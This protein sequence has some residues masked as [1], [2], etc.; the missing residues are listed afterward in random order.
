[1]SLQRK[2]AL[3]LAL[4]ALTVVANMATALWTLQFMGELAG[5]WGSIQTVQEGLNELKQAAS[6]QA[7]L[8]ARDMPILSDPTESHEEPPADPGAL[9][10]QFDQRNARVQAALDRLNG[11]DTLALRVG[12]ST[13]KNIAQR[14][15]DMQTAGRA[16]LESPTEQSQRAASR[17]FF[18]LHELVERVEASVI[19]GAYSQLGFTQAIRSQFFLVLGASVLGVFLAAILGVNLVRRWVVRPVRV[20]R[21]ATDRLGKG[22]FG[23]RVPVLGRDELGLLSAEVNHMAGMISAMQEERVERERLAAVGEMARRLVHNLRNPL[24]GIRSLAELSRGDIPA[25]SPVQENQERIIAT[26][27]RFERWLTDLMSATTPLKVSPQIGPV[28]TWLAT[29]LEP[30]RPMGAS[31]GIQ[32]QLQAQNAP[33]RAAYDPRHLE[34]AI[35][36]VVTNA[37]QASPRGGMVVV[38]AAAGQDGQSWELRVTDSGPGVPP[39][40]ADKIFRPYFTTKRDGSGIGLAVSR[41]VVEQHGGRIWVESGR[42]GVPGG[43]PGP[44]GAVFVMRLP[45]SSG[46]PEPGVAGTGPDGAD[47]GQ[48]SHGRGRIES[49]VLDPAG[50]QAGRA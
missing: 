45:V 31:R 46:G 42:E 24:A 32:L 41:Q 48:D 12:A 30:L 44:C 33:E 35:V 17:E 27:D 43:A 9:Q 8:W 22:D 16:W 49:P 23:H 19:R 29:V 47:G 15:H 39:E 4:L 7:R 1:M 18:R 11:L 37:I 40:I 25:D 50:A 5:P 14:V 34:Q 10:A 3:L 36:A 28:A 21:E 38:A 13:A 2:F 26:V 6:D 20:L